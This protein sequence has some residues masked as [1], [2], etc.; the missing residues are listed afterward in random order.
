MLD[1]LTGLRDDMTA[2]IEGHGMRRFSGSVP[3]DEVPTIMWEADDP[4]G[5]KTFV[6]LAK[7]AGCS[8]VTM[9]QYVLDREDLD[10]I[11]E[12]LANS[13]YA[14]SDELD[15]VKW[16]RTYVGRTGFIQLGWPHQ[17]VMFVCEI[18]ADWYE[19]YQRLNHM[20]EEFGGLS[21]DQ[22]NEDS[23]DKPF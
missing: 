8:F 23:D 14:E 6:E 9:N 7:G 5:W 10:W 20:A 18:G 4:D 16:L 17:G 3:T 13:M 1:D 11:A 21:I 22:L 12:R 19:R 15:D 2:F